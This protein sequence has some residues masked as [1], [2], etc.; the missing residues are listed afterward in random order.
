W[1]TGAADGC[2]DGL[3][4]Q[5]P[6]H[7]V[8]AGATGRFQIVATESTHDRFAFV[9]NGEGNLLRFAIEVVGDE[10]A[11]LEVLSPKL[12]VTRIVRVR[13]R[14]VE[15]RRPANVEQM[16][17]CSERF[18]C[19]LN[20]RQVVENPETAAVRREQH[21]VLSRMNGDFVNAYGWQIADHS[22]PRAT[23]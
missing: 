2:G 1:T 7:S 16:G 23:A 20:R 4:A 5:I 8:E 21:V 14:H 9:A 18:C 6:G 3:M 10:G 22:L 11:R 15:C 19:V 12:S 13:I 17:R